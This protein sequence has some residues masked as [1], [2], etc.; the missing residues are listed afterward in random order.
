MMIAGILA[1]SVALF[2]HGGPGAAQEAEAEG[3]LAVLLDLTAGDEREVLAE[4]GA[5]W[6]GSRRTGLGPDPATEGDPWFWSAVI[7]TPGGLATPPFGLTLTCTQHGYDSHR[8]LIALRQPGLRPWPG[9]AKVRLYCE[10]YG[11]FWGQGLETAL[12]RG[13]QPLLETW[14]SDRDRSR[15]G[16]MV[17]RG[18]DTAPRQGRMVKS[19]RLEVDR[20]AGTLPGVVVAMEV[21]I[22]GFGVR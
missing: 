5:A 8:A 17:Y 11:V 12:V 7:Q 19:F 18:G 6:P 21:E 1:F 10:A 2:G 4:I 15:A 22:F 20:A 13:A 9:G 16:R 14:T 3:A